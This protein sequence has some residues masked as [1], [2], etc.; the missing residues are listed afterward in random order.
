MEHNNTILYNI[1]NNHTYQL[2]ILSFII[3]IMGCIICNNC[4]KIN[5]NYNNTISNIPYERQKLLD[6]RQKPPSYE[7]TFNIN[8]D[9]N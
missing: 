7:E 5:N 2:E 9:T 1:I 4:I 8:I 6:P 3:L